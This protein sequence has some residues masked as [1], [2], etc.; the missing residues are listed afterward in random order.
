MNTHDHFEE[1]PI[2]RMNLNLN[3]A[4]SD[5]LAYYKSNKRTENQIRIIP[6]SGIA[7]DT[8]GIPRQAYSVVF[9]EFAENKYVHLFDGDYMSR[10]RPATSAMA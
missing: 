10:L 9:H 8:G 1:Q 4:W 7:V 2:A 6:T 3:Y 5:M